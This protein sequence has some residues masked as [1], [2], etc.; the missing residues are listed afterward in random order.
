MSEQPRKVKNER[1][2]L[3][4]QHILVSSSPLKRSI[5][6]RPSGKATLSGRSG[7]LPLST[8]QK[9]SFCLPT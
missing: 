1:S 5:A 6:S 8:T 9:V 2:S 7:P 4:E 3:K